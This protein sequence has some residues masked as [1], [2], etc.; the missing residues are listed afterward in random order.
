[1]SNVSQNLMNT[2]ITDVNLESIMT[3]LAT[4]EGLLPPGGT[5]TEEQRASYGAINVDNK[6]FAEDVL[7]EMTTNPSTTIPAFF[8]PA[9]I[10]ND[11]KFY[12]QLESIASKLGQMQ[13]KVADLKRMAGHEAYGFATAVY[14]TYQVGA[15]AGMPGSQESLE[16]LQP[17][18]E[19]QGGGRPL[20]PPLP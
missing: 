4:A 7:R 9:F 11:L 12:D 5:L 14:A 17:R 8:D 10:S 20:S 1:M 3:G 15:R 16:R 6:N 2:T 18:F 19:G 13:R